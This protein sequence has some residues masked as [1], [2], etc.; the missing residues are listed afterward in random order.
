MHTQGIN[1]YN[2]E[3]V[4]NQLVIHQILINIYVFIQQQYDQ[5]LLRHYHDHLHHINV[6]SKSRRNRI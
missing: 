5:Q 1:H 2:V 4:F 6:F 3:F